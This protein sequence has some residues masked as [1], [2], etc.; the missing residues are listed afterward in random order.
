MNDNDKKLKEIAAKLVKEDKRIDILINES[1]MLELE[2]ANGK[3]G[4]LFNSEHESY[5]V[6]IEEL[7]ELFFEINKISELRM[8]IWENVKS[9]KDNK[10]MLIEAQRFS[11]NIIKESIQVAA[12]IKKYRNTLDSKK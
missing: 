2:E 7:D 6:L 1:I 12:M 10:L 8:I 9:N 4:E 5:A 11:L 3:F